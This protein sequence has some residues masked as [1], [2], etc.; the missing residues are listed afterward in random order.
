MT[1]P[2]PHGPG[3]R[4][5][6]LGDALARPTYAGSN[7]HSAESIIPLSPKELFG[8]LR[9]HLFF[10]ALTTV[11]A[12]LVAAWYARSIQMLYSARTVIRL[13]D[14]RGSMTGGLGNRPS[15]GELSQQ[16][17][18]VLSQVEVLQS[19]AVAGEVV[20]SMPDLRVGTGGF[21]RSAVQVLQVPQ[22]ETGDSIVVRAASGVVV[23]THASGSVTVP[24]GRPFD[25]AG[26]R[27]I[28]DSLENDTEGAI[29]LRSRDD[30]IGGV[31]GRL[32]VKSRENTDVVDVSYS[33][34]D[35]RRAQQVANM[36]AAVFQRVSARTSQQESIRRR[37]FLQDQLK[38]HDSVLASARVALSSFRSR[39]RAFSAKARM[40]GEQAG[41]EGLEVRRQE[42]AAQRTIVRQLL[43]ALSASDTNTSESVGALLSTPE[44]SANPAITNSY[45]QLARYQQMRDSLTFGTWGMRTDSPDIVR[46]D[47][48]MATTRTQLVAA[49]RGLVN[50]LDAR[51]ASL[52]EL[53][54]RSSRDFP[55]L[56]SSEEQESVLEEQVATAQSTVSQLRGEYE[57][58]RLAEAVQA[59]EVVILDLAPRPQAADGI[60][61]MVR[62]AFGM[63]VGVLLGILGACVLD[64][65][66]T[67]IRRRR[68]VVDVLGVREL[69]VIPAFGRPRA[70]RSTLN[71]VR[72]Q[73]SRRMLPA[74]VGQ[75]VVMEGD[76]H[77]FTAEAFRLLRTNLI[78][79]HADDSLHTVVITSASPREGKTTVAA[80]LATAFAHQGIRVLLVDADLRRGRLHTMFRLPKEP[81]LSQFLR[82]VAQL[83]ETVHETEV[84]NLC[85]MS[86]GAFPRDPTELLGSGRMHELLRAA[87]D[88]F[89]LVVIDTAPLLAAADGSIVAAAADATVV[90][91]RAGVTK[92]GEARMALD[93][94]ASVNAKVVGVVMNDQDSVMKQHGEVYYSEYYGAAGRH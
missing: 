77:S 74:R 85:V 2:S 71:K 32:K 86:A 44:A 7:E 58:A 54:A 55:Q 60:S 70:L 51:I 3:N 5:I 69:T 36:V 78:F 91:V 15:D 81:G 84:P 48:L 59:G 93:H 31:I 4:P 68:Q 80:N 73:G 89:G 27:L 56:T 8:I 13:Q 22:L 17:D 19:R 66:N 10:I 49:V 65:L 52:D 34:T 12:T 79:A 45:S 61:P 16:V 43:E 23:A 26:A 63:V 35:P 94:L 29:Y 18:P 87:S 75:A 83:D 42:L 21:A 11:A 20:D 37:V 25:L 76:R 24:F 57:K 40:A 72:P 50:S 41:I 39:E 88:E 46:L 82:G 62:V 90:V 47:Q 64:R 14:I 30:A 1:E 33:D 28:V 9:R 92:E 67:S 53:K 6:T 38:Y